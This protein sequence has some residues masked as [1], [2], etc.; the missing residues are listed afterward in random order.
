LFGEVPIV[1]DIR[2]DRILKISALQRLQFRLMLTLR[3][4][5]NA[6]LVQREEEVHNLSVAFGILHNGRVLQWD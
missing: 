2:V 3:K 1:H 5:G 6:D 4:T